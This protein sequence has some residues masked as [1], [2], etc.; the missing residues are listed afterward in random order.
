MLLQVFINSTRSKIPAPWIS[1][2]KLTPTS[3][4]TQE[5]TKPALVPIDAG[6][7]SWLC[8][9]HS[10]CP[11]ASKLRASSRLISSDPNSV[12]WIL[13]TF[14]TCC[15]L[16]S[17]MSDSDKI[18]TQS[19]PYFVI[20][21]FDK[22]AWGGLWV[23]GFFWATEGGVIR[24]LTCLCLRRIPRV[25]VAFSLLAGVRVCSGEIKVWDLG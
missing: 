21:Y 11:D 23:L 9:A 8:T 20:S 7:C 25:W 12:L 16:D 10:S 2:T 18:D 3:S 1:R 6:S 14:S 17:Y 24:L 22:I 5:T 13:L 4:P 19:L 15:F